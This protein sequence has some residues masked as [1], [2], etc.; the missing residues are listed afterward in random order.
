MIRSGSQ[1]SF[2]DFSAAFPIT[3]IKLKASWPAFLKATHDET[4][5]LRQ[6]RLKGN[7]ALGWLLLSFTVL[8][9]LG[10]IQP[11]VESV[12]YTF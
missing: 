1:Y 4:D 7:V 11:K 5:E 6:L 8:V 2:K 12:T 9:I 3:P 10:I